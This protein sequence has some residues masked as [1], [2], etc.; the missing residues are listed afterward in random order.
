MKKLILLI[1]ILIFTFPV[2]GEPEDPTYR[3]PKHTIKTILDNEKSFIYSKRVIVNELCADGLM[4][5]VVKGYYS[6]S[7]IQVFERVVDR[8]NMLNQTIS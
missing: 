2:Y 8:V 1:F 5:L 3:S 7:T 4:F 6:I